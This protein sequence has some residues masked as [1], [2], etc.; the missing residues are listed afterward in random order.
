MRNLAFSCAEGPR[1]GRSA[2]P[3]A[4]GINAAISDMATYLRFYLADGRYDGA[5][6]L[7][8]TTLGAMQTPRVH[9]GR[10]EFAEIGDYHYGFGLG[11]HHYRGERVI[12]HSG[13]WVGWGTLM[14][15]LTERRLDTV[16]L[17]NRA[18][19]IKIPIYQYVG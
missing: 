15:M 18:P 16:I 12:G 1:C 5:Q 6:L 9:V 13:G 2:T 4:G 17:A 3:P 7:S 10:S 14:V 8:P 19:S 11:C